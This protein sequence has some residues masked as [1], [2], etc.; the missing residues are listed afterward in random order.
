LSFNRAFHIV[1]NLRALNWE[2]TEPEQWA[3]QFDDWLINTIYNK[4]IDSLL[5]YKTLAPYAHLAVPRP[6]H[7]VPL[8]IALGSGNLE[9]FQVIHQSYELGT[10]SY[11]SF[12]F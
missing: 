6:E 5:A 4:D 7:F 2:Q 10:L 1:H 9:N 12:E 11:L 8:Y 3:V